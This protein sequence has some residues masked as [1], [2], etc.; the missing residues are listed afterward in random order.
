MATDPDDF[1]HDSQDYVEIDPRNDSAIFAVKDIP[2][3]LD[4]PHK[5]NGGTPLTSSSLQLL[6]AGKPY[7]A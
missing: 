2:T 7:G 1:I 4:Y 5:M 6:G 3:G